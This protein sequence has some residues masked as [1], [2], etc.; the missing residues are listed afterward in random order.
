VTYGQAPEDNPYNRVIRSVHVK[1]GPFSEGGR[2]Q[3]ENGH[4]LRFSDPNRALAFLTNM[5]DLTIQAL[6]EVTRMGGDASM[7][8]DLDLYGMSVKAQWTDPIAESPNG[9]DNGS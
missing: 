4:K 9:G 3:E 6:D 2:W 1:G 8:V 7:V 5:R